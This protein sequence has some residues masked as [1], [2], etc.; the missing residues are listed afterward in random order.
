MAVPLGCESGLLKPLDGVVC[1]TLY[2]V[3]VAVGGAILCVLDV[4]S[5][6]MLDKED[7]GD[8]GSYI[9][10]LKPCE[11]AALS[12]ESILASMEHY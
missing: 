8:K 3:V 4:V 7:G 12:I 9:M 1:S 11:V 5:D 2:S 6:V 10:V